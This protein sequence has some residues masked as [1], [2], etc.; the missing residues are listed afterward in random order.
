MSDEDKEESDIPNQIEVYHM[1]DPIFRELVDALQL[2]IS[3]LDREDP[4]ERIA[5]EVAKDAI[6]NIEEKG[7]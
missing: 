4:G 3:F 6:K 1:E 7:G 5:Y 2:A